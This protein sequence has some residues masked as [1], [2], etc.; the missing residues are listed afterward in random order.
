MR[1]ITDFDTL[2]YY[3]LNLFFFSCLFVSFFLTVLF[4]LPCIPKG[5]KFF[6]LLHS[7]LLFFHFPRKRKPRSLCP[8]PPPSLSLYSRFHGKTL[9]DF[10]FDP[11]SLHTTH[12]STHT[13]TPLFSFP[14]S[15][16]FLF[17][18][19]LRTAQG[20]TTGKTRS[21]GFERR[22]GSYTRH[23]CTICHPLCDNVHLCTLELVLTHDQFPFVRVSLVPPP[24][25]NFQLRPRPVPCSFFSRLLVLYACVFFTFFP[26]CK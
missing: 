13:Y 7:H 24:S 10:P 6:S 18:S 15:L 21:C 16:S 11:S 25:F 14:S 4:S 26:Q 23:E 8:P 2:S 1:V 20:H 9:F 12:T 22:G 3:F 17:E 5:P 19:T